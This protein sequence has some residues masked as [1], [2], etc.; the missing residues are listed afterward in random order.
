MII[1]GKSK[2]SRKLKIKPYAKPKRDETKYID[3][4]NPF[5]ERPGPIYRET[6]RPASLNPDMCGLAAKKQENT[7]TGT[8]IV[9]IGTLHKSNPIPVFDTDHCTDIAKMRR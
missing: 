9:G 6:E 5:Q 1:Y 2:Q 4:S 7:Y 3:L 8:N